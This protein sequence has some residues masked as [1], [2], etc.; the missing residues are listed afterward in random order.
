MM[1]TSGRSCEMRRAEN[2]DCVK[3]TM[4]RAFS[5]RAAV[6]A[7]SEMA[8]GKPT[9]S[10]GRGRRRSTALALSTARSARAATR[11]IISTA[12]AG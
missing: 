3:A 9:P 10:G 2:P 8:S 4:A 11:A 5:T 6:A 1:G 12:S 7:A